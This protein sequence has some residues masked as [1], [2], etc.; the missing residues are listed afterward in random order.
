MIRKN[1]APDPVCARI[2]ISRCFKCG[3]KI[4]FLYI[5]TS[6]FRIYIPRRQPCLYNVYASCRCGFHI[7]PL[8]PYPFICDDCATRM[9]GHRPT[10]L[11]VTMHSGI[12]HYCGNSK[13][14]TNIDDWIWPEGSKLFYGD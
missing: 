14:L 8:R 4:R 2:P 13:R 3:N 9:H 1:N 10:T 11:A 5:N 6:R 12:C 7:Y